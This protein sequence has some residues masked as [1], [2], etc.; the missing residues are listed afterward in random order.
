MPVT[1]ARN[2][3]ARK[4]AEDDLQQLPVAK[5][6]ATV[7]AQE[8]AGRALEPRRGSG[9]GERR[10]TIVRR[11]WKL[12]DFRRPADGL[13]SRRLGRGSVGQVYL[14]ADSKTR[15]EVAVK[16]MQLE[17][18]AT[19]A[20]LHMLNFAQAVRSEIVNHSRLKHPNIVG[21][22]GDFA[23][24]RHYHASAPVF[25]SD[26]STGGNLFLVTEYCNGGDLMSENLPL[27][28][29]VAACYIKQIAAALKFCHDNGVVHCD[30]K[31]ENVMKASD[32]SLKL[33]DFGYS[34]ALDPTIPRNRK[35][36]GTLDY[37]APE[38]V[39]REPQSGAV[40][41]WALGVLTVELVCGRA[42]FEPE[43]ELCLS[44]KENMDET[45]RRIR[46]DAPKLIKIRRSPSAAAGAATSRGKTPAAASSK[47][48]NWGKLTIDELRTLL[49]CFGLSVSGSKS[50]LVDR[51]AE[52]TAAPAASA[53][54]E[55][56][57]DAQD[58]AAGGD[59]HPS[60]TAITLIRRML[61]KDPD[62]RPLIGKV[63]ENM[64]L[65]DCREWFSW[66][67]LSAPQQP[68]PALRG[69]N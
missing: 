47:A 44:Y 5:K 56:N 52:R 61:E 41:V 29:S 2:T 3:R 32:G 9:N 46:Y 1:R 54:A 30:V 11:Q 22:Y 62:H 48:A 15:C 25:A 20:D 49:R 26:G 33:G 38:I 7:K 43:K 68:P 6:A 42:P 36:L 65:R 35:A 64:W 39:D 14:M 37:Q 57:Q 17:K 50:D 34:K 51:L 24:S 66:K 12:E 28:D 13:W 21:F 53:S 58:V 67:D 16:V 23:T 31:L 55:G 69:G 45:F 60:D 19:K 59:K 27:P 8:A 10:G 63:L 4:R 40:D 18:L